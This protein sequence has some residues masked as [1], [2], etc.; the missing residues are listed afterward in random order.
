MTVF[1]GE[2]FQRAISAMQRG[3]L[4]AAEHLLKQTIAAQPEHIPALNVLSSVVATLGRPQEAQQYLRS[5]LAAYDKALQHSPRLIEAWLGRGQLLAQI[6]RHREAVDSFERAIACNPQ[7]GRAHL[8]RAKLLADAG[9]L[10]EA[11][12]GVDRLLELQPNSA[13]ARVGRGNILFEL[14]RYQEALEAF[15]RACALNSA[16]PEAWL[17]RGNALNELGQ[18]YTSLA[19]YDRALA[20]NSQLV[21]AVL[22]RGNVL[23]ALKRYDD[24]LLAYDKALA[25]V[26][27][28]PEAWLNRGNVLNNVN[29]HEDAL[30][31]FDRALALRPRLAEAWLGRG[32]VFVFLRRY[33]DAIVSYDKALAIRPKLLEAQLGRGNVFALTKQHREAANAYAAV[34]KIEPQ[35]PFT[36]GLLLHQ[37][38]LHC[39]W[40]DFNF[41]V[42]EMKKDVAAGKLSVEPFILQ[43][44]SNSPKMLQRCTELYCEARYPAKIKAGIRRSALDHKKIRVGYFSGEFREQATSYLIVGALE[45]HD[46][47]QFE[48]YGF[49]NGWD[50]GSEIRRRINAAVHEMIELRHVGDSSAL[51]MVEEKR[52]DIMVNLNGYFGEQRMQLFTHRMAPIQVNYLG[53]P[54]TLGANYIDYIIADRVVIPETDKPFYNEKV[55]YLPNCYQANDSKMKIAAHAPNRLECGLPPRG[56]VFCCFNNC[57]KILPD[58]FDRWM[59]ILSQVDGSV[60]WLLGTNQE[61]TSNLCHEATIRYIDPRRLVFAKHV[62]PADHLARHALADLFLDTLPCN[63]HTTGSDALWAGLPLLTCMG[64][65]FSGR[66]AASLLNAIGLPELVTTTVEDYERTAVELAANPEKLTLL[67]AKLA[68]NRSIAPLFDTKLFSNH[69]ETAYQVMVDRYRA[70]RDPDHIDVAT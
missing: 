38:M 18:Y 10:E 13:D 43:S 63:A 25:I 19:T 3:E 39:D 67:K 70:G 22:G 26:P 28:L 66:V 69:L 32:N 4:D 57:Y 53:F 45:Q 42:D 7:L 68:S 40:S 11:L 2:I 52:I 5:A 59:R 50:D 49:D 6:G 14:R 35:H 46:T 62:P 60:L 27:N 37:K 34:L 12:A 48:I 8:L 54:G 29:R 47:S 55:V 33:P 58:I 21:G 51:A 31:A 16:L 30:V 15:D 56:F 65:A 1:A 41:S 17:G 20:L 23:N 64:G 61:A 44:V 9:G 36:K 24:A